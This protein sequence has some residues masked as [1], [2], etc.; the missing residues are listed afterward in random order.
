M[1]ESRG[2]ESTTSVRG[3]GSSGVRMIGTAANIWTVLAAGVL[4]ASACTEAAG[5]FAGRGLLVS[6]RREQGCSIDGA[7]LAG[8]RAPLIAFA[9]CVEGVGGRHYRVKDGA[10]LLSGEQVSMR[11]QVGRPAYI[12]LLQVQAGEAIKLW[13][14]ARERVKLAAQQSAIFP[15]ARY[16]MRLDDNAG[17]FSIFAIASRSALDQSAP[18]LARLLK[19]VDASTAV[20]LPAGQIAPRQRRS[21]HELEL[22]AGPQRTRPAQAEQPRRSQ[23]APLRERGLVVER[24][25]PG[26]ATVFVHADDDGIAVLEFRVHHQARPAGGG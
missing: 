5:G 12:T 10:T 6:P 17:D 15:D 2:M 14:P 18:A 16:R 25:E 11:V 9:L 8:A 22:E 7:E 20:Q 3:Y 13:P 23:G 26:L 19:L 21:S 24:A 4:C 1:P